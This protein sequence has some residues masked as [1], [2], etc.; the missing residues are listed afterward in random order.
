MR[1]YEILLRYEL[2]IPGNADTSTY[3]IKQNMF[4]IC[5]KKNSKA[6]M[7]TKHGENAVEMKEKSAA[8]SES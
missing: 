4:E 2:N 1:I 5:R 7:L 8:V 3:S 6:D